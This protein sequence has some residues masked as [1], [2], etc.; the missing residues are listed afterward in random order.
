MA[1]VTY[2][3]KAQQRY[4][5][6]PVIDPATGEQKKTPVMKKA[7]DYETGETVEVQKKTKHGKPVF[8][9]V[10]EPDKSRPKPNL[11]CDYPNCDFEARE[12]K[13]GQAYKHIT[14]KS[15]PYGG[16]QKNRHAEHPSWKIWEYSFSRAAQVAQTQDS[17]HDTLEAFEFTSHDD[18]DSLRDGLASEAQSAL[19]DAQEALDSMPEGLQEGSKAQENVE[20]LESWVSEIENAEAPD[21]PEGCEE[22]DGEGT[23]SQEARWFVI[24]AD[25]SGRV[26][27]DDD[28]GLDTE[29]EAADEIAR[30]VEDGEGVEGEFEAEEQETSEDCEECGGTGDAPETPTED[31]AEEAKETLREAIDG[32]E[33]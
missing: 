11:H 16:T 1:R 23:I 14:P 26:Q 13:P 32:C 12:I 33:I 9:K 7:K 22:C 31:W 8:M 4:E 18:F 6:K 30:M 5:T 27:E 19:D 2:V 24:N 25:G 28:E 29:S 3:K 21:S 17:M 20:A 10:T 15:G